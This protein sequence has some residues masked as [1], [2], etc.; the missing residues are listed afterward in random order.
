MVHRGWPFLFCTGV[1][2]SHGAPGCRGGG[3]LRL[4]RNQAAGS[5]WIMGGGEKVPAPA[6]VVNMVSNLGGGQATCVPVARRWPGGQLAARRPARWRSRRPIQYRALQ[7]H[8]LWRFRLGIVGMSLRL[9]QG[10]CSSL[11]DAFANPR[12]RSSGL[13]IYFA[14]IQNDPVHRQVKR[15]T[16]CACK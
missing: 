9:L 12:L 8:R 14:P 1:M 13:A 4:P 15:K 7:P 5:S 6:P 10:G 2:T 16:C 3:R 11:V